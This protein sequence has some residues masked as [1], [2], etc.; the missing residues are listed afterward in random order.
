MILDLGGERG[1]EE[2]RL[3]CRVPMVRADWGG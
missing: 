2:T 1:V 3:L